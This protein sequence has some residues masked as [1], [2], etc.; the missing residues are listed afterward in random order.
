MIR[1]K[2]VGEKTYLRPLERSD[3]NQGYHDWINDA[4]ASIGLIN[5][6]PVNFDALESYFNDSRSPHCVMFAICD[7][8]ND[9][10]IGNARLSQID[11]V[12]RTALYGRLVGPP[13]YRGKG[14]GTDALIQLLRYGFHFIGLNRIWSSAWIENEATLASND[15]AGMT[16]EGILHQYVYK[17]GCFHDC[18]ILAMLREDFDRL[19]GGPEYWQKRDKEMWRQARIAA[20]KRKSG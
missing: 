16:R 1:A 5:P 19:H 6:L 12:H 8:E 3:L 7:R 15:R 14:Y 4:E 10:Y 17:N 18:V 20:S 13:E 11:W 2:V 9:A